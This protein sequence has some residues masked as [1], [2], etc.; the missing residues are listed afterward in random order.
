MSSALHP[1]TQRAS[2]VA[3]TSSHPHP[4]AH[5]PSASTSAAT[6]PDQSPHTLSSP[7]SNTSNSPAS[8]SSLAN[9]LRSPQPL[10]TRPS[11]SKSP[12]P[13]R[14]DGVASKGTARAGL[15][16]GQ[17]L[18]AH[19][20]PRERVYL[21]CVQCRTRKVKC[22]GAKPECHN[23]VRRADPLAGTCSYDGAP[24][25]RGKDRT[26]GSR[27]F[28]AYEAKKTRTTRSRAEEEAKRKKA[29]EV[30]LAAAFAEPSQ[31]PST[32]SPPAPAPSF[33]NTLPGTFESRTHDRLVKSALFD[34]L[35]AVPLTC[36]LDYLAALRPRNMRDVPVDAIAIARRVEDDEDFEEPG[37]VNIST[38]PG[39][40]FTRETWWDALL[41]FYA[42]TDGD[43]S[44]T[45]TPTVRDTAMRGV[46]ADLRFFWQM[47]MHWFSFIH[48]PRFFANV[49]NPERR[50]KV[51]P[52]L[53]LSAAALAIFYQGSEMENGSQ[54]RLR[55]LQLLDQAHA[56]FQ[57]SL[58][59]GWVDIGLVQAAWL[60]A[61]FELQAHPKAST[62]RTRSVF[63]V[64][65][66]LIR[67]LGLTTLDAD[68]PRT[69][70]FL[71]GA[72]PVVPSP[73]PTPQPDFGIDLDTLG[74][75]SM[76]QQ[77]PTTPYLYV[78]ATPSPTAHYV[79]IPGTLHIR[80]ETPVEKWH[81]GCELYSLNVAWPRVNEVAPTLANMPMWL[82]DVSEGEQLKE[83][84]RR[85]VWATVMLTA[86]HNTKSTAGTDVEPQHL[87]IKD[88]ANYALLFPGENFESLGMGGVATSKWSAWALY[89]RVQLVWHS[90][91]R[92]RSDSLVADSQRAQW[93]STAWLELDA[94]EGAMDAHSC[95]IQS[96][97]MLQMREFLFNTR[98][99][100]SNDF[101]RFIPEA[102]TASN[103]QF[104]HD[105]AE[106]W[107]RFMLHVA[108]DIRDMIS[109]AVQ[110]VSTNN[111]R[112]CFLMYWY[113]SQMMRALALWHADPTI[114]VALEVAKAFAPCVE[115]MM[116]LWPSPGQ[117]REYEGIR[118]WLVR[119][120]E[121]AGL[122]AP[123]PVIPLPLR[124][125]APVLDQPWA[126]L[127]L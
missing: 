56:M 71:P 127:E 83:E 120:C 34:F 100:V 18:T 114:I 126:P 119:S 97:M 55:A 61:V 26:P 53:I 35:G 36:E 112:R 33:F 69:S 79:R 58:S 116:M 77:L 96:G 7:H 43:N 39:M 117:R 76:M 99:L 72:V 16:S 57:A 63:D 24:R 38:L 88:P 111:S 14:D 60:L 29:E 10:R 87:W 84:C 12:N 49:F 113:M 89:I 31:T 64:L 52:S 86:S 125:Q 94:I 121:I 48:I 11:P 75:P 90:C 27:K 13:D 50:S 4:A 98:M 41:G 6:S 68:D 106:K 91:L 44:M 80:Y 1:H 110:G 118:N 65:D 30:A 21:A 22:D 8:T 17:P 23:C 104:Y 92:V 67:S 62:Q 74:L 101:R 45:L 37:V 108:N 42:S 78:P 102:M 81:C 2:P 107:M 66:S 5:P 15:S 123:T 124:K 46:V 93:A 122:G 9:A 19:G 32:S 3:S 59:A 70:I 105:K 95:G 109:A 54:G 115:Y 25:R 28:A 103:M 47:S 20:K 73:P 40:R 82:E 85:L 51:Q